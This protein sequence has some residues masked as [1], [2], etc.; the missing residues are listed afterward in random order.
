VDVLTGTGGTRGLENRFGGCRGRSRGRRRSGSAGGSSSSRSA[1]RGGTASLTGLASSAGGG[2]TS[3]AAS[4]TRFMGD[5]IP[6]GKTGTVIEEVP[7]RD[8]VVL[9]RLLEETVGAGKEFLA[10]QNLLGVRSTMGGDV[11][12]QGLTE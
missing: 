4:G 9:V 6:G 11:G 12:G 5:L 10:S 8:V 7:A 3:T 2:R 1:S